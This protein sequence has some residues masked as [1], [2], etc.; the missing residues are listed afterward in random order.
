MAA[1]QRLHGRAQ[2]R[3]PGHQTQSSRLPFQ[4]ISDHHAVLYRRQAPLAPFLIPPKTAENQDSTHKCF[5]GSRLSDPHGSTTGPPPGC[6]R[7]PPVGARRTWLTWPPSL[8]SPLSAT[9]RFDW[10]PCLTYRSVSLWLRQSIIGPLGST[11]CRRR[12]RASP[13]AGMPPLPSSASWTL[14]AYPSPR[15]IT[16]SPTR[17]NCF[18]RWWTRRMTSA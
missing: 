11:S 2:Q 18:R 16:I 8:G 9:F 3:V 6:H 15:C 7:P 5:N 10:P 12:S 1:N 14:Q 4:R 17:P 13:V